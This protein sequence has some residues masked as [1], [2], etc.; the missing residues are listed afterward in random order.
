MK[1]TNTIYSDAVDKAI[2]DF[3][4]RFENDLL[5]EELYLNRL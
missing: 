5:K 3:K 4:M 2:E 1:N